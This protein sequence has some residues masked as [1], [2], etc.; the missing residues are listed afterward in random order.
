MNQLTNTMTEYITLTEMW[1]DGDYNEVAFII[2]KEDWG[3]ARLA[4]FCAYFNRFLGSG[5]LNLLHKFL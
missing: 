1:Q 4:E 2:N 3:N 5:Q